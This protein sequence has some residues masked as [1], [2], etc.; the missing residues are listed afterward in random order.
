MPPSRRA[1]ALVVPV[2]GFL[3]GFLD[4]VW[5]KWVPFPFAEL[6]N[7]TA[8]WAVAAFAL[9]WWIRSGAVRAAVAA[10]VLLIVAVPSYYL[11]ATLL[12][13]D[14]L[15][16]IWALTSF[17]WMAFGVVAGVV[18]GVAGIWARTD[19]WRRVVGTALPVAVFVEE[20]LR[21]AL[22]SGSYP[23]A[24]WNVAIDL[25]LAVLL[26]VLIGRSARVRLLAAAVALPLA[27]AGA[28]TFAAVAG[29]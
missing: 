1:V 14:D 2:A 21:F 20:A 8:T 22:K 27:A 10:S 18:F 26:V 29:T 5:I 25:G 7:S 9:G 16:V 17:V 13:G 24:W 3:L 4:F 6:G 19:G 23:G 28:L 12:Q 11:A 15:A